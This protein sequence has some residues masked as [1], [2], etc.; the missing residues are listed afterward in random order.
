MVYV[1]PDTI[2]AFSHSA[3]D[4]DEL[5]IKVGQLHTYKPDDYRYTTHITV[6]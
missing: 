4:R 1:K 2:V 6:I 3:I 5:F